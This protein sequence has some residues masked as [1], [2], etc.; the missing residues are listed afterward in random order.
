MD[1][2]ALA[3]LQLPK[4]MKWIVGMKCEP[5]YRLNFLMQ[6][7]GYSIPHR[8]RP[9]DAGGDRR[10][11]GHPSALIAESSDWLERH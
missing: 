11:C 2:S 9:Y 7:E 1:L 5:H 3:R 10:E 6:K 8:R 4:Q